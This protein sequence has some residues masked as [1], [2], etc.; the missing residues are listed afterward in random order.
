MRPSDRRRVSDTPLARFA[1]ELVRQLR[2]ADIP[3]NLTSEADLERRVIIP[4]AARVAAKAPNVRL[5]V[6]PFRLTERCHPDCE[7]AGSNGR[8]VVLG[9]PRCW[10]ATKPLWSVAAFGTYHTFDLVATDGHDRL[11]LEGKLVSARAGRMPN[12][13]IQRFFGQCALAASK[14]AHVIGV[15]FFQGGLNAKRHADTATVE[16]WFADV[17]V[18]LIIREIAGTP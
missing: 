13:D 5:F 3:T 10:H 14:H 15:L 9:C 4:T 1:H 7:R 2:D 12:G 6:H 18:Q 11:A 8:R 17:V 16:K